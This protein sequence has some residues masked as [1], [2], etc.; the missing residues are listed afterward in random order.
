[1]K[2]IPVTERLPEID[3]KKHK[4]TAEVKIKYIEDYKRKTTHAFFTWLYI[5]SHNKK[6]ISD[7]IPVFYDL[8]SGKIYENVIFWR[9]EEGMKKTLT[10]CK[11]LMLILNLNKMEE[12]SNYTKKELRS[13]RNIGAKTVL[14][15]QNELAK[16]NVSL[17]KDKKKITKTKE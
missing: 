6:K 10:R 14:Y 4:A 11:N 13:F 9:L 1:M 17:K 7:G 12:F 2:W 16:L 3:Y 8:W 15:I 5:I